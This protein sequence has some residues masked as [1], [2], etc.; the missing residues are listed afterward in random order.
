MDHVLNY[1]KKINV[2]LTR[3]NYLD[4]AY[5]GNPPEELS[6]EEEAAL[7]EELQ[8]QEDTEEE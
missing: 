4:Y 7:P 6:A 2:P 3:E 5:F 1:M 8:L